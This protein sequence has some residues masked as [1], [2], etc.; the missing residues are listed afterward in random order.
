MF[1]FSNLFS[2]LTDVFIK[3]SLGLIFFNFGYGKLENL[4]NNEAQN[5]INMVDSIILFGTAPV[6]F[7]WC[8]ALSETFIIIG[9]IY[10]LFVVLPYSNT[11]SRFSGLLALLI[12][13]VILYQH[14]YV[15]GDNIFLDG[16]IE[17]LNASEGKKS[18]YA[19]FL[20]VSLSMYIVFN[21]Q[22]PNLNIE[23]K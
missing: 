21:K 1:K 22:N 18:V 17:I 14:I 6:F 10:G 13:L 23:N 12:S 8:L 2:V 5:L 15:W 16:P 7:S 20:F 4:I 9:L 19:Q 3:L 11:I